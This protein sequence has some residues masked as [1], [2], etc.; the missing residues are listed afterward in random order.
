MSSLTQYVLRVKH[1]YKTEMVTIVKPQKNRY[2]SKSVVTQM[3][4]NMPKWLNFYYNKTIVH[5]PEGTQWDKF[6]QMS[7]PVKIVSREIVLKDFLYKNVLLLYSIILVI[8]R[9]KLPAA[10]QKSTQKNRKK[11]TN[12]TNIINNKHEE[13]LQYTLVEQRT[14]KYTLLMYTTVLCSIN[15]C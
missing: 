3:L 11:K 7:N 5:H 1:K 6:I 10:T 8:Q 12:K 13:I 15:C 9:V 2:C 14:H 4:I